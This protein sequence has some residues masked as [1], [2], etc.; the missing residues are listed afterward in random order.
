MAGFF[1]YFYVMNDYGIK[2]STTLRLSSMAGFV[3]ADGD[4]YNP[5]EINY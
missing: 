2:I 5:N 4:I 3:P 1:T